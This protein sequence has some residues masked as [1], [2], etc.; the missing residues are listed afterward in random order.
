MN[1]ASA[2]FAAFTLREQPMSNF[3]FPRWQSV[4]AITLLGVL[5][6]L[7]PHMTAPQPGLPEAAVMSPGMAMGFSVVLIW[8]CFLMGFWVVRWWVRR[9]GRW[10]GQ[11]D[12]FNLVAA[13]WFVPDTLAAVLTILGVPALLVSVLW[14]YSIWVAGNALEGA[15]PRVSLGY[16][17]GGIGISVVL[18]ML[19]LGVFSVGLGVF[20]MGGIPPAPSGVVGAGGG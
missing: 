18:M 8:A 4:A 11:G 14:L 2:G 5:T 16:A 10:D 20:L 3:D 13:M 17:I 7:D 6:G 12:L 9:G 19:V 15:I 1:I